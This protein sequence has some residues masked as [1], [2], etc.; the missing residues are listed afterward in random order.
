MNDLRIKLLPHQ[1][2]LL[3][4]VLDPAS[5]RIIL[6]RGDVGLGKSTALVALAGLLLHE[7]PAARVLFIVPGGTYQRQIEERLRGADVPTLLVDRYRFREMLD[8]TTDR[9]FW[10]TGV[11]TVLSQEFAEQPDILG[12]L[13]KTHWELVMVDEA[14]TLRGVRM[15]AFRSIEASTERV[16]LATTVLHNQNRTDAFPVDDVTVVEWRRSHLTRR[17]RLSCTKFRLG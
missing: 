3:D 6:L 15:E 14:H 5:K 11:V 13:T 1:T 17:R 10:P 12:K 2:A 7:Q 16:V 9:E 4:A 8:S